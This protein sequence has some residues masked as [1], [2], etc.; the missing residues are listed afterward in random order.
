MHVTAPSGALLS[1]LVHLDTCREALLAH[2]EA[3]RVNRMCRELRKKDV[4]QEVLR[5]CTCRK[6]DVLQQILRVAHQAALTL[7][8]QVDEE[9]DFQ[10]QR[11]LLG[12]VPVE[13]FPYKFI[14]YWI[15]RK[16]KIKYMPKCQCLLI[17]PSGPGQ[18]SSRDVRQYVEC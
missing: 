9:D 3:L 8:E 12:Y 17:R 1:L 15:F 14:V 2:E 18:S 6:E 7:Y 11:G 10:V 5:Y 13:D 4:L 16:T